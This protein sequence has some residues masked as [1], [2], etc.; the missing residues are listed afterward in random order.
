[1]AWNDVGKSEILI[2]LLY[3]MYYGSK[4]RRAIVAVFDDL[5]GVSNMF[6]VSIFLIFM[7]QTKA[8]VGLL[9]QSN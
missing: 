6:Q 3:V 9:A 2:D 7:N 1:M 8:A 5:D 4:M